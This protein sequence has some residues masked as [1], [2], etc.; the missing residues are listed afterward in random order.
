MDS[1][2]RTCTSWG[3]SEMTSAGQ[4][5]RKFAQDIPNACQRKITHLFGNV[6]G[7]TVLQ[8]RDRRRFFRTLSVGRRLICHACKIE[9]I[10]RVTMES[11]WDTAW[12]ICT[13]PRMAATWPKQ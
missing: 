7:M 3:S 5:V 10:P 12:T 13:F 4:S 1:K 6:P 11:G 2:S 8:L 9:K